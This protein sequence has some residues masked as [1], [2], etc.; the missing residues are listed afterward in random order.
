MKNCIKVELNSICIR[1]SSIQSSSASSRSRQ[2]GS[3]TFTPFALGGSLYDNPA[4]C[5]DKTWTS[6]QAGDRP[7]Q[8]SILDVPSDSRESQ[9]FT[10]GR[11]A[12]T[13][14]VTPLKVKHWKRKECMREES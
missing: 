1:T 14:P 3:F 10:A 13:N 8:K 6:G 7:Q 4:I 9:T 12:D 11:N 5:A 2:L